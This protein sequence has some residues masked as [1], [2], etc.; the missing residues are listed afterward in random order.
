KK[1]FHRFAGNSPANQRLICGNPRQCALETSNVSPDMLR[2]KSKN[3][4]SKL[5]LKSLCL[6]SENRQASSIIRRLQFCRQSTIQSRNKM[7]LQ[8]A[9]LAWRPITRQ[10]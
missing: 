7:L 10:H 2:N 4:F 8:V 9:D 3:F 1:L 6:F 5:Y